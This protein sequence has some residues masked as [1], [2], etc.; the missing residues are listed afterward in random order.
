MRGRVASF[1]VV[2]AYPLIL[3]AIAWMLRS[4]QLAAWSGWVFAS[5]TD[6][7]TIVA[8]LII[9]AATRRWLRLL[10]VSAVAA[11]ILGTAVGVMESFYMPLSWLIPFAFAGLVP[12]AALAAAINASG[13]LAKF[14]GQHPA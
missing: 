4:N 2:A 6:P 3:L 5:L 11:V 10:A 9:G 13:L 1:V 14:T 7:I 8:G 12:W